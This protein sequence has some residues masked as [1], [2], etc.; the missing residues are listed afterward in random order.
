MVWVDYSGAVEI[1]PSGVHATQRVYIVLFTC[2]VMRAVHFEIAEDLT[3]E[4]FLKVLHRFSGRRSMPTLLLSDNAT[5]F[6]AAAKYLKE[7]MSHTEVIEYLAGNGCQWKFIP[8]PCTVVRRNLG[9][10]YWDN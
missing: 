8:A 7:I 6:T 10:V 2:A 5:H 4:T 1:R 3:C 9:T